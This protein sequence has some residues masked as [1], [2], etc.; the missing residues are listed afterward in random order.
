MPTLEELF[1]PL[2][3]IIA[4]CERYRKEIEKYEDK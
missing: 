1:A 3:V 2:D 4:E